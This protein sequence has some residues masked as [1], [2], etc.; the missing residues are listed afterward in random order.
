[1][2]TFGEAALGGTDVVAEAGEHHLVGGVV[3]RDGDGEPLEARSMTLPSR[4]WP[5]TATILPRPTGTASCMRRPRSR[6]MRT[7][8]PSGMTPAATRPVYSPR[9]WP[10]K[11]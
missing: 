9:L 10:P 6:T 2:G 5:M 7:A 4:L 11:R 8:S 1:G 3:V